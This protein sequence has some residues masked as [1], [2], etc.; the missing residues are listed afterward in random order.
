MVKAKLEGIDREDRPIHRR[1]HLDELG[2]VYHILPRRSC[3]T[4]I[5]Q[6]IFSSEVKY[7]DEWSSHGTSKRPLWFHMWEFVSSVWDRSGRVDTKSKNRFEVICQHMDEFNCN[8]HDFSSNETDRLEKS[9]GGLAPNV[10]AGSLPADLHYIRDHYGMAD[11]LAIYFQDWNTMFM[12]VIF[13][14]MPIA[15]LSLALFHTAFHVV[16][17]LILFAVVLGVLYGLI[18][19]LKKKQWKNHYLDYRAS[20]RSLTHPVFLEIGWHQ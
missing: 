7:P 10:K 5:T 1:V 3:N 11:A 20:S 19:F 17:V 6:K 4:D 8:V 18:V 2:P 16:Q 14:L 15:V 12:R 9:T 13:A